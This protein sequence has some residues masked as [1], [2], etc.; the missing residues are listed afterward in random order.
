MVEKLF[1][2][3]FLKNEDWTYLW[4]NSPKLYTVCFYCMPSWG[5]LQYIETKLQTTC[6]YL[7]WEF[8]FKPLVFTTN[9]F[10]KANGHANN[11]EHAKDGQNQGHHVNVLCRATEDCD[12]LTRLIFLIYIPMCVCAISRSLLGSVVVQIFDIA[13]LNCIKDWTLS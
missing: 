6:F 4:I 12:F 3:L 9:I 13:S 11:T 10:L 1:P 5:L 8:D 2:D 7:L